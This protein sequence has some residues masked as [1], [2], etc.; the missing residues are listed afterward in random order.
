[1]LPA[2]RTA[3]N[4]LSAS[5]LAVA[6]G[7]QV[8]DES[9]R[10]EFT[11]V[12]AQPDGRMLLESA[13]VPQRVQRADGTWDSIDLSLTP[14]DDGTLRPKAS[15]ADVRFSAGGPGP[16]A[17]LVRAGK[18]LTV[19]WPNGTLPPPSVTEESAIY[20]NVLPDVDLVVRATHEGFSHVLVVKTAKAA[21]KEALREIKFELGG[22][23]T[24]SAASD[25]SLN[26]VVDGVSLATAPAPVMW[27][28]AKAA[29]ATAAARST[30][31]ARQAGVAVSADPST[32]EGPGDGAEVAPIA[33]SI[34]G[35]G[36][37]L[38]RP[39]PQLL[40]DAEFPLYIDPMWTPFKNKWAYANNGNASNG[41]T[42]RARVGLSPDDGRI[43]RSH[44]QFPTSGLD[45]KWVERAY[46]E[47]KVDHTWSC[48]D[49]WTHMFH[50]K[51]INAT[52]RVGWSNATLLKHL[53]SGSSHANE[54]AGCPDSPQGDMTVNFKDADNTGPITSLMREIA[55]GGYQ[56]VTVA[57]SA[58]NASHEYEDSQSRWKK[59][60]PNDARLYV[61][62]DTLPGK[63]GPLS[64]NGVSCNSPITIGTTKPKFAA[65]VIDDDG[66]NLVVSWKLQRL[67]GT[68]WTS[69]GGPANTNQTG[70]AAP[71]NRADAAEITVA[72][73]KTYRFQVRTRDTYFKDSPESNWCQFRIDTKVP[74]NVT[75]TG[76]GEPGKRT[77]F[78]ITSTSSDV[79]TFRYG[80]VT[81]VNEVAAQQVTQSNG[82]VTTKAEVWLSAPKWGLN[83]L[84]LVAVD[85]TGN[86]ADGSYDFEAL[87]PSAAKARWALET[88]PG[89]SPEAAL[90]DT[91]TYDGVTTS[92]A[93]TPKWE[94][95]QRL[96][97]GKS[98]DLP[99]NGPL[100]TSGKVVNTAESFSVAAWVRLDSI[101]TAPQT[102]VSQDGDFTSRFQLQSRVE[103][104]DGDGVVDNSFCFTLRPADV[105]A[106]TEARI[107]CGVDSAVANRWTH[108][109][110]IYDRGSG[111]MSIRIGGVVKAT[112]TVVA[113]WTAN[114][115]VRIGN[116]KYTSTRW[117]EPVA[118]SVADVQIFDRA[119]TEEDVTIRQTLDTKNAPYLAGIMTP[120][121]VGRWDF[122]A[123]QPCI[124]L[125][126]EEGCKAPDGSAFD[127][128]LT[129][130]LGVNIVRDSNPWADF[131]T[132][133][134]P[135]VPDDPEDTTGP[136]TVEYGVTQRNTGTID[137]TGKQ[138]WQNTPVLRT[139]Q[140]FTVT[141]FVQPDRLDRTMTALG[142]RGV[143]QSAFYLGPRRYAI[144]GGYETRWAVMMKSKDDD[145]GEVN[146]E[147]KGKAAL[148]STAT[149][150]WVRLTAVFD[151]NRQTL[152]LY[153]GKAKQGE[154]AFTTPWNAAGPL[155]VGAA[156]WTGDNGTPQYADLWQGGIDDVMVF[157][158]TKTETEVKNLPDKR[159]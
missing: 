94:A 113:G 55:E 158:G 58:G 59:F 97:D 117:V 134:A 99:G 122:S 159:P 44:F 31:S 132:Y 39:D 86:V 102:F 109:A 70:K 91:Q 16:M 27:D 3:P 35:G 14:G 1:M 115:P 112:K 120:I 12:L 75:A 147:V 8:E 116:R 9:Q 72:G 93:G 87:P 151:A 21:S 64:V 11:R 148:T 90:V 126:A 114:G 65:N 51:T 154:V 32:A 136:P 110:G 83:T 73:D 103:D 46:V 80:W 19:T 118:G 96:V 108:V 131:N 84:E 29:P 119:I 40:A 48:D 128:R 10:T 52:P 137:D 106:T 47:M 15:I 121:E 141:A 68:T 34:N 7:S 13:V 105:D 36:D 135:P 157:Q 129:T 6:T 111:T 123:G 89:L 127:R 133:P 45:D 18:K 82:T 77:K 79:K 56:S 85:T 33:T 50:S 2:P 5:R 43:Y 67:D 100:T 107:V 26:A 4:E 130:T 138:I 88:Y 155:T 74:Q 92:L 38:L 76:T 66:Q 98:L 60:F 144:T 57:F 125:Q 61:D 63:P 54:G 153:V 142:Q 149:G 42:S 49:T 53:S 78:T 104:Y 146:V 124:S 22:D 24:V 152:A 143:E 62:Y 37:L 28:S 140:S 23:A 101:G 139:D 17:T 41:D 81:A 71:G 150:S 95:N 145:L 30:G 69:I 156:W 25:G 20:P